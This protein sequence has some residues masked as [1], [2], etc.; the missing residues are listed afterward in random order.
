MRLHFPIALLLHKASACCE[1]KASKSTPGRGCYLGRQGPVLIDNAHVNF[2]SA[3]AII[4]TRASSLLISRPFGRSRCI[5]LLLRPVTTLLYSSTRL[6]TKHGSI[7]PTR[8]ALHTPPSLLR[9]EKTP[10]R[11]SRF[12]FVSYYLVQGAL[13]AALNSRSVQQGEDILARRGRHEHSVSPS[14]SHSGLRW[15]AKR[16][17]GRLANS[18]TS[19]KQA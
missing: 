2:H 7:S 9:L 4:I 18:E 16:R 12:H 14:S 3:A 17:R 1:V 15:P 19:A 11:N 6:K 8:S 10:C 13:T 5:P